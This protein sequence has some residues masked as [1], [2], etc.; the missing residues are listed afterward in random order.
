MDDGDRRS[1]GRQTSAGGTDRTG[2]GPLPPA[3][4]Q[5]AK[6]IPPHLRSRASGSGAG[7]HPYSLQRSGEIGPIGRSSDPPPAPPAHRTSRFGSEPG[8]SGVKILNIPKEHPQSSPPKNTSNKILPIKRPEGSTL[9]GGKP[10]NLLVNHFLVRFNPKV[11]IFHYSL[12]INEAT[13]RGKRPVRKSR[14]KG[15][16]RL[17][18]NKLCLDDPAQF[19]LNRTAYDGERNLYSAVPLPTG[20]FKVELS[21][22]EDPA[23]RI[24]HV[25]IKLMTEL[26]LSK[27]EDY[28]TGKVQHVPRDIL[29]GMDLVMKENPSRYRISIDRNF[30]PSIFREEDDFGNGVAA[31]RGF[32]STLRPTSQGLALCL[33]SSVM[34]FRKPMPVIDFLKENIPQFSGSDFDPYL[35]RRVSNA[36][37]GLTVR[38]THRLTKQLFSITGLTTQSTRDLWFD[39]VDPN[40][41]EQTVKVSLVEYFKEKYGKEIVY[42]AVPC[43]IVG[44]NNRMNHVPMEFCV[45]VQGQRYKK[46]LLGEAEQEKFKAKCLARPLERRQ[47]ISE[48][49]EAHDGPYGDVTKN[50]G[51]QIDKNMTSVE[52][53]VITPPELKLCTPNGAVDIVR[54]ENDKRQWSLSENSVVDGKR[55][56]TWALL[57]FRSSNSLEL[58]SKDFIKNLTNRSRSLGI[59]MEE[60]LLS[61]STSMR[62]LSSL[63]TLEQYLRRTIRE[64]SN[65]SRT[66]LQIIICVMAEKH[67]SGYKYLKW[68]S[69]TRIGVIT[70][71]CL[72]VHANRG[73][74]KFLVNLCLKINAKL[75]GSNAE[76]IQTLPNFDNGAEKNDHVMFIGADVNH[77]V[78][79]RSTNPSI[80]AVVSTI[81]WPAVTRYAA[82]VCP[83]HHRTEKILDFGLMCRDLVE[84]Y[85]RFNKVRPAKIVVFR[86]GV[87]EGQFEMVLNEEL[88]D[89]KRVVCTENY[90]PKITLVVAQK[91]HQTRLFVENFR[92][93]GPT[94]NVPPG[95]VVDTKIVHPFEFDFYLC[96]H[97][98]R[99]GTSKAVRYSVLLN[100]NCFTPDQLQ[101]LVYG[102]C[103][104][105]ARSTRPVSLVPPVYYADL[106][107]YR[108]RIFEEV[109]KEVRARPGASSSVSNAFDRSFYELHP[110]LRDV[111]FF[112]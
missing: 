94:G 17:I 21:G 106:V 84:T 36:L 43:L 56:E 10:I 38:V 88:S 44:R 99:T 5:P 41:R 32:Q 19:P 79:K 3:Q 107:A 110:D 83:Q 55:I 6:Y 15:I 54:I 80:A 11:T 112:V 111:M 42:Q 61:L 92:D 40:G 37:K 97:Y 25:S 53:R 70:Q 1:R 35:R 63:T 65:K 64:A 26:K 58:K 49:M 100:E 95:T 51:F 76:L 75:G 39:F 93:V 78:S 71:C 46:E 59:H 89:L 104:T 45:L 29:Q 33:D 18:R 8:N 72:S 66:K 23:A 24:Y 81:N 85:F 108:G 2:Q 16:L 20:Q 105:F 86:D 60:P 4:P 68:L 62:E 9:G 101:R 50:F 87:S 109:A 48:M 69:E 14:H 34:A 102:L 47:T 52:G 77:P 12:D 31:Y 96:S 67:P 7:P 13:S 74:E 27:L 22:S 73:D 30:Y 82:R 90:E 57:E 28:L 91:R 98:G 103:F